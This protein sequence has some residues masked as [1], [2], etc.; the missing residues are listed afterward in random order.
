AK[1]YVI[2]YS[3]WGHTKTIAEAIVKGLEETNVEAKLWRV[4]ETLSEE[5]LDKMH[6]A[7]F[8]DIPVIEPSQLTEADGY[9]FGIPTR[10]G[11]PAAQV[12]AFWDATGQLWQ[13]GA[14]V[15][16]YAG[17]FTSTATQHGGQETTAFSFLPQLVHH[18]IL[19]VPTG[20]SN[21]LLND[22]TE[23]IG[24]SAYG[25]GTVAEG[26]GSRQPSPK[27][28]DIAAHQGRHFAKIIN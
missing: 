11:L 15:G 20:Y 10:Y 7:K 21:P 19:F 16:K 3:T 5:V 25:A 17:I 13:S 23:V 9:L 12:R 28:L 22:N 1:V 27:E 14:L 18:G 8:D 2:I 6:A 24:G 26:D 4:Q